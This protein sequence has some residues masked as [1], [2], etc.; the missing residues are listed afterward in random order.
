[1]NTDLLLQIA[2][3]LAQG[4]AKTHI[5]PIIIVKAILALVLSTPLAHP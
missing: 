1:M 4:I 5:T 3:F 2:E